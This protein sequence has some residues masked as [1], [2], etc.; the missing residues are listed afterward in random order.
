MPAAIAKQ[1]RVDLAAVEHPRTL[2]LNRE[3][4]R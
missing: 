1:Q 2:E 3:G 4:G